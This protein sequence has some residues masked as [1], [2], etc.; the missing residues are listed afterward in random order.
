MIETDIYY[1]DKVSII[2]VFETEN[3]AKRVATNCQSHLTS[4]SVRC[5]ELIHGLNPI[6]SNYANSLRIPTEE[7]KPDRSKI[8]VDLEYTNWSLKNYSNFLIN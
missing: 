4:S 3:E 7:H 5:L 2:G 1:D 6:Y 8:C